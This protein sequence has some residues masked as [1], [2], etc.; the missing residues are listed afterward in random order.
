MVLRGQGREDKVKVKVN[1]KVK[2]KQNWRAPGKHAKTE[3]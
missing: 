1:I 3:P 2:V